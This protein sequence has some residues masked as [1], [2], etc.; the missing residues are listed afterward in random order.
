MKEKMSAA[1]RR[2]QPMN[3]RL[4]FIEWVVSLRYPTMEG[5][6]NEPNDAT[7]PIRPNATAAVVSDRNAA[8]IAQKLGYTDCAKN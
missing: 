1:V 2:L 6:K 3:L 8:G 4:Q 5:P 7:E